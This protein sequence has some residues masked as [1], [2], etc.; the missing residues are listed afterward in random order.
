MPRT[1]PRGLSLPQVPH[2]DPT[3]LEPEE[4]ERLA[5]AIAAPYRTFVL[6]GAYAGLRHGELAALRVKQVD[7][8]AGTIDVVETRTLSTDGR[9]KFG[10][11]KSRAGRRTVPVPAFVM[12]ELEDDISAREI[13]AHDLIWTSASG[14]PLGDANFR[15]RI[16]KPAAKAAGLEGLRVHDLR[17]TCVAMWSRSL[18]SPR[19]AAKWAGHSNPALILGVYG[20]VFADESQSV[21]QRLTDYAAGDN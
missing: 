8:E 3:F 2:K 5:A 11:P 6:V 18:A 21:M 1:P 17:H 4:V 12:G 14:M 20:G 13:E 16:W 15:S 7:N 9:P 19:A 10:P